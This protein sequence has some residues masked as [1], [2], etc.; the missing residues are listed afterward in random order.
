[1]SSKDNG[2]PTPPPQPGLSRRPISAI[3]K[4][5]DAPLYRA[6]SALSVSALINGGLGFVFWLLAARLHPA[7]EVGR[8]AVAVSALMLV[9]AL[10]FTGPFAAMI[11]FMPTAGTGARRLVQVA[12]LAAVL[13][14]LV[15]GVVLLLAAWLVL[16][17]LG[18]LVAS[19]TRILA[20]L[21]SIAFWVVFS[22]Q[23][24]VLTGLRRTGWVPVENAVFGTL[25]ALL[26]LALSPYGGAWTIFAAWVLAAAFMVIPVNLLLFLQ[27]IPAHQESASGQ[28]GRYGL[29]D[30]AR[31]SVGTHL[32]GLF[33]SLPDSLMPIIVLD[34]AGP[35]E[36]A[37][38]YTARTLVFSL[39]PVAVGIANAVTAEAASEERELGPLMAR[40]GV[41]A[42]ALF[43]PAVLLLL[44]WSSPILEL[45]GSEYEANGVTILRLLAAGLVPFTVVTMIVSAFRIK[46][47]FARMVFPAAVS[48]VLAI[49]ISLALIPRAGVEGAGVAWVAAQTTAAVV[50]LALWRPAIIP[51]R[52]PQRGP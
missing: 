11:R 27:W 30:V 52:A 33:T 38:F 29:A 8:G 35:R 20:F 39:R 12:Y 42:A 18:F 32:A 15:S 6:A 17:S 47:Q 51:S 23:D 41:F 40:G 21:G 19:P 13:V 43:A 5:A 37:Y 48:A 14:A 4:L 2:S 16:D 7:E 49:V 28:P 26:L 3:T 36:S 50:A 22:I 9:S 34:A 44:V 45:F 25:K 31:F 46:L 1:M 10:G 24:G